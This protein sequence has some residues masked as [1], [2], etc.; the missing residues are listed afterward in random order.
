MPQ[1][2][3]HILIPIILL[4][5]FRNF[6]VKNKKSFPIYYVLI[7]GITGLIP[8]I[9]IAVYYVLSFFGFGFEEIH[10]T[11]SHSIFLVLLFLA[12]GFLFYK[13][14]SKWLGK[15]HLKLS[16]IFFV[17]SFG[18][19]THLLLDGIIQGEL[20]LFYPFW[21]FDFGLDLISLFPLAWQETIIPVID[22]VLL[23]GWLIYMGIKRNIKD[24]I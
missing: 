3:T 19:F 15:H 18:T 12:L 6:F 24:F 14:K 8:D 17:I 1:A 22:G 2:V 13:F 10:R 7:G 9:D 16:I 20:F 11:F 21:N 23:T 5:L 4:S